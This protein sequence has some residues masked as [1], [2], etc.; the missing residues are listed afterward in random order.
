M[1]MHISRVSGHFEIYRDACQAAG[2]VIN[3]RAVPENYDEETGKVIELS[4]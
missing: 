1:R 3:P 4:R 2:I